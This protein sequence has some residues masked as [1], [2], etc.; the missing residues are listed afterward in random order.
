M[1][2][3]ERVTEATLDVLDVLLQAHSDGRGIH[4]WEIKKSIHRSGPTVYGIIDRL[5]DAGLIEGHW[6]DQDQ[7]DSG[8]RRR[9][10]S[11]TGTGVATATALLRER[12]GQRFHAT[13]RARGWALIVD[14]GWPP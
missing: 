14:R 7:E 10:Y 13:P 8:P 5:Q 6:E 3:I 9:F 4:G 12:R 1:A 11:L 2:G